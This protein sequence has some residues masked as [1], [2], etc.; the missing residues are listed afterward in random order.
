MGVVAALDAN[1]EQFG[2]GILLDL[3]IRTVGFDE[4]AQACRWSMYAVNIAHDTGTKGEHA[5]VAFVIE[6]HDAVLASAESFGQVVSLRE[7]GR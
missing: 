4:S 2:I 3:R 6:V 1:L 7:A 5:Y